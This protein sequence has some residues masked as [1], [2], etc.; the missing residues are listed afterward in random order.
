MLKG[1]KRTRKS[2]EPPPPAQ[3]EPDES[4][5]QLNVVFSGQDPCGKYNMKD[6]DNPTKLYQYAM[7][8]PAPIVFYYSVYSIIVRKGIIVYKRE[9]KWYEGSTT[10]KTKPESYN[11]ELWYRRITKMR[12]EFPVSGH[13][14]TFEDII[15]G[16]WIIDW[17]LT[18]LW[19]LDAGWGRLGHIV[20]MLYDHMLTFRS[21]SAPISILMGSIENLPRPYQNVLLRHVDFI[22]NYTRFCFKWANRPPAPDGKIEHDPNSNDAFP[23]NEEDDGATSYQYNLL[24]CPVHRVIVDRKPPPDFYL[25]AR[26]PVNFSREQIKR[27]KLAGDGVYFKGMRYFQDGS[28]ERLTRISTQSVTAVYLKLD[29]V[30]SHVWIGEALRV[31]KGVVLLAGVVGKKTHDMIHNGEFTHQPD[32]Y[33]VHTM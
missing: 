5:I 12:G 22:E 13:T 14:R 33:K 2:E 10:M 11:R 25:R 30:I 20:K 3:E 24:L 31:S 19:N 28:L 4:Y 32:S 1:K 23:S 21:Y 9:V 16:N 15:F 18:E 6:A 8:F 27:V 29:S 26:T 17:D 7:Y